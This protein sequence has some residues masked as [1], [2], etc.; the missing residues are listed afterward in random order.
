ML[1]NLI[2]RVSWRMSYSVWS[3]GGSKDLSLLSI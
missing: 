1:A 3:I 2:A